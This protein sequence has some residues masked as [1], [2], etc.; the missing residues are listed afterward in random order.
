LDALDWARFEKVLAPKV[1]G[2]WNLHRVCPG[3]PLDW[4]LIFSSAIGLL[5][6]PGQANHAAA[7]A[8]AESFAWYRRARGLP[9]L[10]IDWGA[11]QQ[12]GAAVRRR[13]E[14]SWNLAGVRGLAPD[15]GIA[16]VRM[17]LAARAT[18]AAVLDVDWEAFRDRLPDEAPLH[19]RDVLPAARRK[20]VSTGAADLPGY[21]RQ[22]VAQLIG[23][24][25]DQVDLDTGLSELG[26]DSLMAVRLRNRMKADW[27]LDVSVSLLMENRSVRSLA[28]ALEANADA[29][30]ETAMVEGAI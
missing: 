30:P 3:A 22:Q 19:L 8:V 6:N 16:A 21:L 26:V 1:S 17:L 10:C 23:F 25:G 27:N 18:H 15:R 20:V 14:G 9:A 24:A 29:A 13:E 28:E 11:W 2:L 7:S 5:G 4:F 12:T